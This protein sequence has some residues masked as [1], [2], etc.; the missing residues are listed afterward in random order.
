MALISKAV[1]SL[2]ENYVTKLSRREK[3]CSQ[4]GRFEKRDGD[5]QNLQALADSAEALRRSANTSR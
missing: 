1:L 5:P 4:K 2:L 3:T